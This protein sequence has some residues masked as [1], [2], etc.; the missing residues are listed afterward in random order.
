M[1]LLLPLPLTPVTQIN[2]PNGKSTLTFFKLWPVHPF[3]VIF[4]SF[5]F[6][7]GF[8]TLIFFFSVMFFAVLFLKLFFFHYLFC[9]FLALQCFFY[10]SCIARSLYQASAFL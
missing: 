5:T 8:W 10:R 2:L 6:F 3:K 4:F 9:G 7:R 1:R